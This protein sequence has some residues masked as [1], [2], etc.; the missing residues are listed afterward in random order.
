M[1]RRSIPHE[2]SSIHG[3]ESSFHPEL[4]E[5][6]SDEWGGKQANRGDVSRFAAT[7]LSTSSSFVV[8]LHVHAIRKGVGEEGGEKEN[9]KFL[10]ALLPV[11]GRTL[12]TGTS[13]L[14]LDA[15]SVQDR[16]YMQPKTRK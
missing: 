10:L 15:G 3:A 7:S 2:M 11:R 4:P 9:S 5:L 12:L 13:N 6:D 16:K 8:P 14:I 1:I